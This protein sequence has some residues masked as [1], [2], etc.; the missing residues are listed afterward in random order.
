MSALAGGQDAPVL[1]VR[2]G[3][4]PSATAGAL[5]ALAPQQIVVLGGAG[6]VSDEVVAE[7]GDFT[8]GEVSRLA[9][10]NRYETAALVSGEL[11]TADTV[12]VASGELFPD[13][14]AGAAHAAATDS[15]VLL[16]KADVVPATVTA[17]I[18]RLAPSSILLLG[19]DLVVSD[20]VE[21]SLNDLAPVTR[22]AGADRYETSALLAR[23]SEAPAT[24]YVATGQDWPDGLTGAAA[25][26]R[27]SA[28]L[29]LTRG[30][31]LT[32]TIAAE[33]VRLQAPDLVV[34]GGEGVIS[35]DVFSALT[36]LNY[37]V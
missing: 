1:L 12:V 18:E 30:D 8:D 14:L 4:V 37:A 25:A 33:L 10:T 21:E 26:G 29:L 19:G 17:E 22:V 35:A 7:L 31:Q 11:A 16:V 2:P 24:A 5:T 3:F 6:A 27:Q 36:G 34:L 9:G 13:A 23:L 20:A 32:S 15:P 28:P